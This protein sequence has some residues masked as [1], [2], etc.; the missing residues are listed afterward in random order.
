[1][2]S[3]C[4]IMRFH[5]FDK[6]IILLLL[7]HERR[8]RERQRNT[9]HTLMLLAIHV[10]TPCRSAKQHILTEISHI[11]Q[12]QQMELCFMSPLLFVILCWLIK[13]HKEIQRAATANA[14]H[15]DRL[16]VLISRSCI[17]LIHVV[18]RIIGHFRWTLSM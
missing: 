2:Q 4:V 3:I 13:R 14:I 9:W 8:R 16:C 7:F 17:F 5:V 12:F 6:N 11:S 18:R 1:M 10:V 15:C